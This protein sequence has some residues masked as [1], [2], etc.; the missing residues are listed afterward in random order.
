MPSIDVS[1]STQ[2][3]QAALKQLEQAFKDLHQAGKKFTDIDLGDIGTDRLKRDQE[4]ILRNWRDMLKTQHALRDRLKATGQADKAPWEIDFN[5]SHSGFSGAQLEEFKRKLLESLLY[6]ASGQN[7]DLPRPLER[8]DIPNRPNRPPSP[9]A[10]G[11]T[12]E[13]R[14]ARVEAERQQREEE[15]ESQRRRQQI[16]GG[17]VGGMKFGAGMMGL[18]TGLGAVQEAYSGANDI[19]K[20]TDE[21]M[22]RT[23]DVGNGFEFLRGQI[24]DVGKGLGVASDEAAKLTLAFTRTAHATSIEEAKAG[25][26]AAVGLAAGFGADKGQ[27]VQQMAGLSLIGSAGQG[28]LTTKDKKFALKLAQA[29]GQHNVPL[30]KVL[31]DFSR[32]AE[33]SAART[34]REPPTDNLLG[35]MKS[36]YDVAAKDRPGLKGQAGI[37]LLS[38]A[39][40]GLRNAKD[41]G[42]ELMMYQGLSEV[43][44]TENY[45]DIQRQREKHILAPVTKADGT[46]SDQTAL[47][48]YLAQAEKRWGHLGKNAVSAAVRDQVGLDSMD[49]ADALIEIEKSFRDAG[50]KNGAGDFKK[51]LDALYIDMKELNETGYKD[52]GDII[53]F[54]D[55]KER[56]DAAK[57]KLVNYKPVI[58]LHEG[59][60]K[61]LEKLQADASTGD[62]EKM[63]AFVSE[64]IKT[65]ADHGAKG[66]PYS[67]METTLAE[68]KDTLINKVGTPIIDGFSEIA[69]LLQKSLG[70][71]PEQI[72]AH[73]KYTERDKALRNSA[74]NS[75]TAIQKSRSEM[76]AARG[77]PEFSDKTRAY[78]DTITKHRANFDALQKQRNDSYSESGILNFMPPKSKAER[79]FEQTL[80]RSRYPLMGERKKLEEE[81]DRLNLNPLDQEWW[82]STEEQRVQRAKE[83]DERGPAIKAEIA[84]FKEQ[85]DIARQAGNN[86][87]AN[88]TNPLIRNAQRR[89]TGGLIPGGVGGGDRVPAMLTPGEFVINAGATQK[90]RNL[91][92]QINQGGDPSAPLK[93]AEG[94]IVPGTPT[95]NSPPGATTV[96]NDGDD[97]PATVKELQKRLEQLFDPVTRYLAE[98]AHGAK[99]LQAGR[100]AGSGSGGGAA[101]MTGTSAGPGVTAPDGT[102][103]APLTDAARFEAQKVLT[104]G[105]PAAA[106]PATAA[107]TIHQATGQAFPGDG[108]GFLSKG[109]RAGHSDF[110]GPPAPAANDSDAAPPSARTARSGAPGHGSGAGTGTATPSA[111]TAQSGGS[112]ADWSPHRGAPPSTAKS[113]AFAK[114]PRYLAH[115]QQLE[116][117]HGLPS[118]LLYGVMMQESRGINKRV[119][120]KG[121]GG[122]FQFMPATAD[123]FGLQDRNDPYAS[124]DAA[125][126]YLKTIRKQSYVKNWDEA[127]AGYNAGEGR[128][129]QYGGIPPFKET[130]AYVPGVKKWASAAPYREGADT[131]PVPPPA[132]AADAQPVTPKAAKAESKADPQAPGFYRQKTGDGLG[133]GSFGLLPGTQERLNTPKPKTNDP[134]YTPKPPEPIPE[135]KM[136]QASSGQGVGHLDIVMHH[137]DAY[138][139]KIGDDVNHRMNLRTARP[140][141]KMSVSS[142]NARTA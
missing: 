112:G 12:P 52:L 11:E 124:A 134:Q 90:H 39:D 38:R 74:Q 21:F 25:T 61:K 63:K 6:G 103:I 104:T 132:P 127:I 91:L 66:T 118:G 69:E 50:R 56:F 27:T 139:A 55:P 32:M 10:S 59:D 70:F 106:S 62:P 34:T 51:E 114:D 89:A 137:Q 4:I 79:N 140:T 125:A 95:Y 24:I 84:K 86:P 133:D 83:L 99:T 54:E 35:Y 33:S 85:E 58:P 131:A 121:A 108:R 80:G 119:S 136:Q 2:S 16:T 7:P 138:G 18:Q 28:D 13:Q 9:G 65:V 82:S 96:I 107:P 81:L 45:L 117:Q 5:R 17:I 26:N 105:T 115:L 20:Y 73:K 141:G 102:P 88:E 3:A 53:K 43:M 130:Q 76:E 29:V 97:T 19:N 87:A 64:M 75:E 41:P 57:E 1:A 113:G 98:L 36:L 68:I 78:Q 46:N 22:R 42:T 8:P 129:K 30:E 37:A 120:P 77:T 40:E 67:V 92:Q 100:G 49:S 48:V 15:R 23:Q 60:Q 126:K 47:S 14:R 31:G 128:I 116:K 101:A 72:D 110:V 94:G 44:G 109:N 111:R 93:F 135:P 142:V 122:L 123:R 71:T